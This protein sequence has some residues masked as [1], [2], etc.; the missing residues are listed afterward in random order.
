[1]KKDLLV[2]IT[3]SVLFIAQLFVLSGCGRRT[4]DRRHE[5]SDN[6]NAVVSTISP[7]SDSVENLDDSANIDHSDSI[8]EVSLLGSWSPNIDSSAPEILEFYYESDGYMYYYDYRVIDNTDYVYSVGYATPAIDYGKCYCNP[9]NLIPYIYFT[10]DI[11]RLNEGIITDLTDGRN[12]YRISDD[13]SHHTYSSAQSGSVD[14]S[15]C[16]P[17]LTSYMEEWF[18][19]DFT[20]VWDGN[21]IWAHGVDNDYYNYLNGSNSSDAIYDSNSYNSLTQDCAQTIYRI[22]SESTDEDLRVIFIV[23]GDY[24]LDSTILIYINGQ[25]TF[26]RTVDNPASV[27]W[28]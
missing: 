11:S 22:A 18:G 9:G 14:F 28:G 15:S 23:S 20:L 3:A 2:K 7:R 10:F 21:R 24:N 25:L 13:T 6:N 17:E 1:M 26:D 4:R 19:D 12:Y 8:G 5:D 27:S 16:Y